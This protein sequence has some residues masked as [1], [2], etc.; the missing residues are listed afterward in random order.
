MRLDIESFLTEA[1]IRFYV[2]DI[3]EAEKEYL[4]KFI[5]NN[6]TFTTEMLY[7]AF[8]LSDEYQYY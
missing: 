5:E 1:Y 8:A 7:T 6:P 3:T 4:T 2:R